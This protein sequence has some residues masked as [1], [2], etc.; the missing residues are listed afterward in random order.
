MPLYNYH[1]SN[2][3]HDFE[4]MKPIA[5]RFWKEPCPSCKM[6]ANENDNVALVIHS[7]RLVSNVGDFLTRTDQDFR[8][9]LK[10]IKEKHPKHNTIN[11]V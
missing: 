4:A 2:C 9:N 10:R 7:P 6:D 3:G 1:C 11:T 8:D 5:E